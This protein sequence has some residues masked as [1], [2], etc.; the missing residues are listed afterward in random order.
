MTFSAPF[1]FAQGRLEVVPLRDRAKLSH[2]RLAGEVFILFIIGSRARHERGSPVPRIACLVWLAALVP[3]MLAAPPPAKTS[4]TVD[5]LERML[6]SLHDAG[7]SKAARQLASVKLT[8]R[9]SAERLARWQNELQGS[10]S[11]QALVALADASAFLRPPA[12]EIPSTAP[13][14]DATQK[15]ML[16]RMM[17]YVK[18]TIPKLPNFVALR[19]T[20]AFEITTADLLHSQQDLTQLFQT[21]QSGKISYQAIGPAKWSGLPNGQLFW[22][23][24]FAQTVRYREGYEE[25]EPVAETSGRAGKPLFS[26]TSVGEFGAILDVILDEAPA[27]AIVWDHWEQGAKGKVAVFR[28]A[29]PRE[30]SH[31]AVGF[32]TDQVPDYPAY[33]G[34]IAVDPEKGSVLRITMEA[35]EHD[36][37][38]IHE[39]FIVVEFG[40]MQIA[41]MDYIVPLRGVAMVKTYDAFANL[42]AQPPPIA[43]QTAIND[44]SFTS[45]HVFRTKSRVV[46]GADGP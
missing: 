19:T 26:L 24:S 2:Y 20:T 3:V 42:S 5:E 12:A 15:L 11:R 25:E 16:A 41:G 6:P 37:G 44:I 13:P 9:A 1:D 36:P 28:Y 31:F 34:E 33:H 29:V 7:D 8:E 4:L 27:D 30:R 39:A 32:T 10:R 40:P 23:G 43:Y 21:R 22:I 14:D 38:T 18:E 35:T 46:D 45:Y 17:D